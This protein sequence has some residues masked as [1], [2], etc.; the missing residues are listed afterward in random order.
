[1]SALVNTETVVHLAPVRNAGR[2]NGCWPTAFRFG[3]C[4][5]IKNK[6]CTCRVRR[7]SVLNM[8]TADAPPNC[9]NGDAV[10]EAGLRPVPFQY[11]PPRWGIRYLPPIQI[12]SQTL[13]TKKD[14]VTTGLGM[15][16]ET[17]A[18]AE[19]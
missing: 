19:P 6:S 12:G 9:K 11:F 18:V 15:K 17:C 4:A 3:W 14:G 2:S 7:G 1:M 16:P 8:E 13:P 10:P 5:A